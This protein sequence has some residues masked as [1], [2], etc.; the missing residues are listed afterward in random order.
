MIED[1]LIKISKQSEPLVGEIPVRYVHHARQA[2]AG[3]GGP[4]G[5]I[6]LVWMPRCPALE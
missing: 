4:L 6:M 5:D 2:R 1:M 3:S